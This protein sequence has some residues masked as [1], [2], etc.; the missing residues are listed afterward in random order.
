MTTNRA[1]NRSTARFYTSEAEPGPASAGPGSV[2]RKRRI[3]R[4]ISH[5]S[6]THRVGEPRLVT[7][8]AQ[9]QFLVRVGD[10]RRL[11]EDR[12]NVG[13]LEHGEARL[14]DGVLVQR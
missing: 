8:A 14:F 6:V 12:R 11:D 10:E 2:A 5:D 9:L 13:G 7:I 4:E 3:A 1:K